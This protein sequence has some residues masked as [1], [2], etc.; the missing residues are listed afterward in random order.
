MFTFI[1][2]LHR[3]KYSTKVIEVS[4]DTLHRI[5]A[6]ISGNE[7]DELVLITNNNNGNNRNNIKR[8]VR[9][10]EKEEKEDGVIV[11]MIKMA[12]DNN[13][14]DNNNN[15]CNIYDMKN[16]N[17]YN[18]SHKIQIDDKADHHLNIQQIIKNFHHRN[19]HYLSSSS[20][21]NYPFNHDRTIIATNTKDV[22]VVTNDF[23]EKQFDS[24]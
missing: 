2:K 5:I 15:K 10:E 21:L 16:E 8:R 17:L 19:L 24:V 9:I 13:D 7:N 14:D 18:E 6:E 20:E 11:K 22:I 23:M 3:E 1:A 12:M 4:L